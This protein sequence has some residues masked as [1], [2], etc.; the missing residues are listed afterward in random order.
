MSPPSA[1]T[2]G[3]VV[4]PQPKSSPVPAF[5]HHLILCSLGFVFRLGF[6]RPIQTRR[7]QRDCPSSALCY[8]AAKPGRVFGDSAAEPPRPC[9]HAASGCPGSL[10]TGTAQ[11]HLVWMKSRRFSTS[12]HA[13]SE[14]QLKSRNRSILQALR[15]RSVSRTRPAPCRPGWHGRAPM[16]KN[17]LTRQAMSFH[18]QHTPPALHPEVTERHWTVPLDKSDPSAVVTTEIRLPLAALHPRSGTAGAAH[19]LHPPWPRTNTCSSSNE[20]QNIDQDGET[21]HVT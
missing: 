7:S 3:S 12:R 1:S 14:H 19:S 6:F 20:K 11:W 13:P 10:H 8:T 4:N 18:R 15:D 16:G 9:P 21:N 17:Q 2:S 5:K